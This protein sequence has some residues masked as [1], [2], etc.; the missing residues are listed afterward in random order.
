MTRAGTVGALRLTPSPAC[1]ARGGGLGRGRLPL[2]L[3][4]ERGLRPDTQHDCPDD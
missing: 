1:G 4:Y 3:S 2:A